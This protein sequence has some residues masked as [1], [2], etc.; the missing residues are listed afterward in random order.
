MGASASAAQLSERDRRPVEI[1]PGTVVRE[2]DVAQL[3]ATLAAGTGRI[4]LGQLEAYLRAEGISASTEEC[5]EMLRM[6]GN[7]DDGGSVVPPGVGLLS[8]PPSS[9]SPSL[10]DP[11]V[12]YAMDNL[13]DASAAAAEAAMATTALVAA[14]SASGE[15]GELEAMALREERA[16][17]QRDREEEEQR[18]R[19]ALE[20]TL[21]QAFTNRAFEVTENACREK[22]LDAE[23]IAQR[24]AFIF[25]AVPALTLLDVVVRSGA[26]GGD[27]ATVAFSRSTRVGAATVPGGGEWQP[28][29]AALLEVAAQMPAA[30]AADKT[31][32]QRLRLAVRK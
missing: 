31:L 23:A 7:C 15:E 3:M 11:A 30:E 9:S 24:E 28:V 17:A 2:E 20:A 16:R 4:G 26:N 12:V 8:P 10:T 19:K 27:A 5:K 13:G 6:I 18:N 29:V 1:S 14:L 22:L 21:W 25:L 32:R